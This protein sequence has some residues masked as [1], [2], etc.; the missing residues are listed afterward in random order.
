MRVAV[1]AGSASGVS[2]RFREAASELGRGLAEA[3]VGIVYGGGHVGL[4]GAVAD[5]C[6]AAGGEVIGVMPRSL[7]DREIAHLGLTELQVTETMHERKAAMAAQADAF[8]ALPGGA[9]TLEE[10]FEV[11]TWQHLAIH[12]K[13]VAVL[14]VDGFWSPLLDALDTMTAHG[15]LK[16][17]LRST[18]LVARSAASLLAEVKAWQPRAPKWAGGLDPDAPPAP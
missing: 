17:D 8:V 4:M 11:W 16:P 5:A 15:F 1:F 18:L 9:G 13:P 3:G 2:P 7:V 14:E 6:L 12:T 10:L